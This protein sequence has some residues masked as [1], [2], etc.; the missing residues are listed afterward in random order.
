MKSILNGN[1]GDQSNDE[2]S[3]DQ[4][5]EVE[6]AGRKLV[7][8]DQKRIQE[9]TRKLEQIQLDAEQ[10][11]E[12]L[13]TEKEHAEAQYRS[14]LGKVSHIRSSLS[15]RLKNDSDEIARQ[16]TTI[17][18][19][20]QRN[21]ALTETV[22]QLQQEVIASSDEADKLSKDLAKLRQSNM[23]SQ[24]VLVR[25]RKESVMREQQLQADLHEAQRSAEDWRVIATEEKTMRI[26]SAERAEQAEQQSKSAISERDNLLIERNQAMDENESLKRAIHD[27]QVERAQELQ[28][29][30]SKLQAQIDGLAADKSSIEDRA[31][32]AESELS[33]AREDLE[34]MRPFEREVKEKNLL[35]GKLRHEAVILNE[36]L[37]KALRL[38]K[39]EG[40]DENVN[41]QLVTNL[42][43]SFLSLPRGDTKR[44]EVLQ[45]ISACLSW[46]DGMK[47]IL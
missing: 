8:A 14:L 6:V 20:E 47:I 41:R 23:A 26:A 36:H 46:N 18:Y 12:Q 27:A 31:A 29:I 19:L 44:F 3:T 28:A 35:I 38:L 9:L 43:L 15:D 39:K 13:Q 7:T 34:R 5:E 1:G 11:V 2:R 30:V 10:R 32:K 45:L 40:P 37:T 24:D 16:K 42:F 22:T 25:E 4:E 21:K 33:L 17:G